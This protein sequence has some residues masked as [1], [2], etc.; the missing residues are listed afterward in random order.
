M[1]E[2]HFPPSA[3]QDALFKL[4]LMH[5]GAEWSLVSHAGQFLLQNEVEVHCSYKLEY[6]NLRCRW[7][8]QK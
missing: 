4:V 6:L 8:V 1:L 2:D 3:K 5:L 7:C